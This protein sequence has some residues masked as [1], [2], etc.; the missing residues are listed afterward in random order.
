MLYKNVFFCCPKLQLCLHYSLSW[1]VRHIALAPITNSLKLHYIGQG[2]LLWPWYWP[3]C[4][5]KMFPDLKIF[6]WKCPLQ[7]NSDLALSHKSNSRPCL[8]KSWEYLSVRSGNSSLKG[9]DIYGKLLKVHQGQDKGN[10]SFKA[11]LG[12][13][14]AQ[15]CFLHTLTECKIGTKG[16]KKYVWYL[17]DHRGFIA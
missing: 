10:L 9:Q 1:A 3:W 7:K 11:L 5:F 15:L 13:L 14:S 8:C 2:W 16:L 4:P 6:Q 12:L 17:H